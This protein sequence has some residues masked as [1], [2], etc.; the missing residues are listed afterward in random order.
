MRVA[1]VLLVF[2]SAAALFSVVIAA[3]PN[4]TLHALAG[5]VAVVQEPVPDPFP[6]RRQFLTDDQLDRLTA[7]PR[8]PLRK[9]TKP[10]FE[11]KVRAAG[12]A[13]QLARTPPQVV[14]ATYRGKY[15]TGRLTGTADWTV[16][17][18]AGKPGLVPL[19]SLRLAITDLTPADGR[20]ALLFRG[21]PNGK[22][23]PGSYLWVGGDRETAVAVGWSARG[24]E[25]TDEEKFDLGVPSAAIA[26]L[27]LSL[28]ND[29]LPTLTT[30]GGRRIEATGPF[31]G[32]TDTERVW[33]WAVGGQSGVLLAVRP[34]NTPG[35]E[36]SAARAAVFDLTPG[37]VRSAFDF[38]L[39]SPRGLVREHTFATDAGVKVSAV[40]G[41]GIDK[42]QQEPADGKAA[43]KLVVSW[44]EG[45]STARL[46]VTSTA[47]L[48]GGT[49]GWACPGV[50]ATA[51][52][53][54]DAIEVNVSPELKLVGWLPGDYRPIV[55]GGTK[56]V[57][58]QFTGTL[59]ATADGPRRP[60]TVRVRAAEPEV[61]TDESL[62]WRVEPGRTRLSATVKVRVVR[63]PVPQLAFRTAAG[64]V[65]ESAALLP[66]D[67]AVSFG[68]LP[69]TPNVWAVEPSRAIPTGQTV[70]VKLE[71]R[72]PPGPPAPD[73]ADPDPA[74]SPLPFP[75]FAPLSAVERQGVLTAVGDGVTP[76]ARTVLPVA[77]DVDGWVVRY[78]GKEPTGTG[79][80]APDATGVT[81]DSVRL[82]VRNKVCEATISGRADD[83]PV[84]S[85]TV[86]IPHPDGRVKA[87]DGA[88]AVPLPAAHL[89]PL[90][91][92]SD[93]W[94]AITAAGTVRHGVY[95]R[96]TFAKPKTGPFELTATFPAPAVEPSAPLVLPLPAVGGGRGDLTVELAPELA[97]VYHLGEV[98]TVATLEPLTARPTAPPPSGQWR[99]HSVRQV[100]Q[101]DGDGGLM[102]LFSGRVTHAAGRTLDVTLPP[103][104]TVE[105]A[106]VGGKWV[107]VSPGEVVRLPLPDLPADG[108]SFEVRYRLPTAWLGPLPGHTSP[109]PG[110]PGEVDLSARWQF[111]KGWLPW[112]S[113]SDS[114]PCP[115]QTTVRTARGPVLRGIGFG[116]GGL[117]FALGVG[118]VLKAGRWRTAVMVF[119]VA[120]CGAGVW[121]GSLG[122]L[123]VLQP[124]LFV[125]LGVLVFAA[126]RRVP[127]PPLRR[128]SAVNKAAAAVLLVGVLAH[129]QPGG[130]PAVVY[131]VGTDAQAVYAPPAVLDKLDQLAAPPQ[132]DVIVTRASY[133][134]AADDAV[135]KCDATFTLDCPRDGEHTFTLPLAGVRLEAMRLDDKDA[136]P[137]ASRPD[138]YT[139]AVKGKGGH[140][141]TAKFAVMPTT[142]GGDREARFGGPEVHVCKVTFDAGAKGRQPDVPTRRGGQTVTDRTATADHGAGRSVAVRWREEADGGAKTT[143]SVKE[144]AV[145]DASDSPDAG[146]WAAFAYQIAGGG[147]ERFEVELPA[148]LVATRVLVRPTDPRATPVGVRGWRIAPSGDGTRVVAR[149]QQPADGRILV[150]VRAVPAKP[151][152][153][154]PVLLFP[155]AMNVADADRDSV[156]AVRFPG[157]VSTGVGVNGAIDFPA[158]AIVKDFPAVPEFAFD[159][160]PPARVVKR[161]AAAAELR[162]T[163]APASAFAPLGAEAIFTCGAWVEVEGA[164]R[165]N[166]K[167]SG[168]AE[169][170]VPDGIDLR[171]VRA[172]GLGG[173]DRSGNK[174]QV[175]LKQP[176]AEVLIRWSGSLPSAGELPLPR[177]STVL[178]PTE[179]TTV[180]VRAAEGYTV[181]PTQTTGLKP[182]A[183]ADGEFA[184]TLDGNAPPLKVDVQPDT[185][186]HSRPAD[187]PPTKPAP[188]TAPTT[189]PPAE[190]SPEALAVPA[191]NP[192]PL[193]FAGGWAI[194]L[195]A[196]VVLLRG[197]GW[198]PERLATVG[199][200]GVLA[201]G[202]GTP[203]GWLFA[204]AA[205]AGVLWR[206]GRVVR[207]LL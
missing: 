68:P 107:T 142:T 53:G 119:I 75:Q 157:V 60:P 23:L 89:L 93:G 73:P 12:E 118:V 101:I 132:P 96:V 177:W 47:V 80:F 34:A 32:G 130:E 58:L 20:T 97:A 108:V 85:L 67:S 15:A 21:K 200:L 202:A 191:A 115:A 37:E 174:V 117:V 156:Y 42:W 64:F 86:F 52:P 7:D 74:A 33:K 76:T 129:A 125:G 5:P 151:L 198:R 146:V 10:E 4:P 14:S 56:G 48:A 62:V 43:G 181:R 152:G 206:V 6:L 27:E 176:A 158:D 192:W 162:P 102:V 65:L 182:K 103:A 40:S 180:R 122:W 106:Q 188:S 104:A 113:L 55:S 63:G 137:D 84:G 11:A 175:W 51:L 131:V 49:V 9:L 170:I 114:D 88:T 16:A 35:A 92:A 207:R 154:A 150:L 19:D 70:E 31:P 22:E 71:F 165:A 38:T 29:R 199:V 39:D 197:W 13:V 98:T 195:T 173:W 57:K 124:P 79:L 82:A 139:V 8:G 91:S 77:A 187:P 127:P 148:G 189:T 116:L 126:L 111:A 99:F 41:D 167:D 3:P 81:V 171:D 140:T 28:P 110:L 194:G 153:R 168:F 178:T 196:A 185:P 72:G 163:L 172:T 1:G 36:V 133:S 164:V 203:L 166:A 169:F 30:V 100:N 120:G 59:A 61:T 94:S 144:A 105:S 78:R 112:P 46:K 83:G 149:L 161:I 179:P 135:V 134:A 145:W 54:V 147:V 138:R 128:P 184:Y 204:A 193:V 141:L 17:N 87:P 109:H 50:R 90:L 159:K 25:E 26:T 44:R 205:T 45:Q 186:D 95:W 123:K 201:A 143:V 18:P 136:F 155:R 190:T 2:A 183:G 66:E 160:L 121:V 24:V 69:G